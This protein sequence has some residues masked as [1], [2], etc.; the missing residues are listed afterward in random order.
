MSNLVTLERANKETRYSIGTLMQF[1]TD[2]QITGIKNGQNSLID[3][4]ELKARRQTKKQNRIIPQEDK[5]VVIN[6]FKTTKNNTASEISVKTG[7]TINKVNWILD[8]YLNAKKIQI[9]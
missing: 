9:P 7:F 4:D 8:E 5:D 2:R 6:L 3:L 1:L